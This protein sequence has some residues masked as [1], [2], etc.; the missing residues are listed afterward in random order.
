MVDNFSSGSASAIGGT[1][2]DRG[3]EAASGSQENSVG[4]LAAK[5]GVVQRRQDGMV[6]L[7]AGDHGRSGSRGEG[8]ERKAIGEGGERKP[9]GSKRVLSRDLTRAAI[10]EARYR[11]EKHGDRAKTSIKLGGLQESSSIRRPGFDGGISVVPPLMSP[12]GSGI[13]TASLAGTP[14]SSSGSSS[15]ISSAQGTL[16]EGERLGVV[17]GGGGGI[18]SIAG[19]SPRSLGS[20][21]T[22]PSSVASGNYCSATEGGAER[23]GV[24]LRGEKLGSFSPDVGDWHM[25]QGIDKFL[26]LG[27]VAQQSP[28]FTEMIMEMA[29]VAAMREGGYLGGRREGEEGV[30]TG[31]GTSTADEKSGEMATRQFRRSVSAIADLKRE[32]GLVASGPLSPVTYGSKGGGGGS[33]LTKSLTFGGLEKTNRLKG[34]GSA[35]AAREKEERSRQ[36]RIYRPHDYDRINTEVTI[37]LT[38]LV[39][40]DRKDS[41]GRPIVVIDASF[42]PPPRL[43]F[44]AV[45]MIRERMDPIV[46]EPYVLVFVT[47]PKNLHKAAPTKV[48]AWWCLKVYQNL[49]RPYKKNVQ[50]VIFIH[51]TLWFSIIFNVIQ[52]FLSSKVYRK[53]VKANTLSDIEEQVGD[54]IKLSQIALAPHVFVHDKKVIAHGSFLK[55]VKEILMNRPLA[56]VAK[57]VEA[58]NSRGGGLATAAST[59]RSPSANLGGVELDGRREGG[60]VGQPSP[61]D[62]AAPSSAV[63]LP[64]AT[65][66]LAP[67][68]PTPGG[69]SEGS[70]GTLSPARMLESGRGGAGAEGMLKLP[71]SMSSSSA[72]STGASVGIATTAATGGSSALSSAKSQETTASQ[73]R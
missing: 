25:M 8:G 37:T 67:R 2:G 11:L 17:G 71:R 73:T 5:F 69:R 24:G 70:T 9:I 62:A 44:A 45:A 59:M 53:F 43:R 6:E 30:L 63:H 18:K 64:V 22:S 13:G 32:N 4:I 7:I 68:T 55:E 58:V 46:Q 28:R 33:L 61:A 14:T 20:L 56:A 15:T 34:Y 54:E 39:N 72:R 29:T 49:P 40:I 16:E 23:R 19:A 31:D 47:T 10:E 27:L 38:G 35:D 42:I 65:L 57:A 21:T 36:M 12:K 52:P 3:T 50:R 60:D 51:L 48:P 1:G 41:L 26:E 66:A